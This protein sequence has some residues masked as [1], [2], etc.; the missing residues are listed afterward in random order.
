MERLAHGQVI[1]VDLKNHPV[2]FSEVLLRWRS[3]P[4]FRE[5]FI[6]LLADAP[7]PSFRWETPPITA[8][9]AGR[10]F[11]FVL[12]DSPEPGSHPDPYAFAGHFGGATGSEDVVSFSN[13]SNDAILVVPCPL[14]PPSAY[15][16]LA[17]FIRYAPDT[18]KHSLWKLVGELMEKRLGPRP[19]WLSTAGAGVKPTAARLS[20]AESSFSARR[21]R[22][23]V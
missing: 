1:S 4:I 8:A 18:Q 12:L 13:L 22:G 10:P 6:A 11:E 19:V 15:G 2:P 21:F 16:H 5:F 23:T 17:A 9:S 3:D 7:F 14:G 20:H